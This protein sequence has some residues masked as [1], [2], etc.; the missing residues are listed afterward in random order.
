LNVL[1]SI[2]EKCGVINP[3][4][5]MGP[6]KAVVVAV[7]PPAIRMVEVVSLRIIIPLLMVYA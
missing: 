1:N 6:Q 3:I 4:N 2:R 5:A 7:N